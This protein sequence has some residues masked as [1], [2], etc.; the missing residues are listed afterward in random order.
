MK[1]QYFSTKFSYFFR[2]IGNLSAVFPLFSTPLRISRFIKN[3]KYKWFLLKKIRG[4]YL[5]ISS[6]IIFIGVDMEKMTAGNGVS[7]VHGR[8]TRYSGLD[9]DAHFGDMY[10]YLLIDDTTV[11]KVA[12]PHPLQ[13]YLMSDG[14]QIFFFTKIKKG[15]FLTAIETAN[16]MKFANEISIPFNKLI[17]VLALLVLF[18]LHSCSQI[19]SLFPG[20]N[21][22]ADQGAALFWGIIIMLPVIYGVYTMNLPRSIAQKINEEVARLKASYTTKTV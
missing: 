8:V 11:Q 3:S 9:T 17:I 16:G 12:V 7:K 13:N 1:Y 21:S 2:L 22:L 5:L 6:V 19:A 15:C 4:R 18:I 10:E 20:G 14:P